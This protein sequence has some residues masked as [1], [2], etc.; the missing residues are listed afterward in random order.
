VAVG[1]LEFGEPSP[2]SHKN[3]Y[4]GAPP[5]AVPESPTSSGEAPEVR[6]SA[7]ETLSAEGITSKKTD[8]VFVYPSASVTMSVAG[9]QEVNGPTGGEK[10]APQFTAP[11]SVAKYV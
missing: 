10:V 4:G 2:K 9:K 1:P 3:R 11:P 6:F 5:D 7:I 8:L